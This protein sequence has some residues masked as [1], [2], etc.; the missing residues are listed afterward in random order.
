MAE[1]LEGPF[2]LERL[3]I[4]QIENVH[5]FQILMTLLLVP[6]KVIYCF[7]R[8]QQK[9]LSMKNPKSSLFEHMLQW[10][11]PYLSE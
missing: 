1:A 3:E 6:V 7:A 2:A 11:F 10:K 5:Q 8:K 9:L 4:S